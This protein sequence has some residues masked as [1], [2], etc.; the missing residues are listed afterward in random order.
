M[1]ESPDQHLI[2][3]LVRNLRGESSTNGNNGHSKHAPS[4]LSDEE[5]ISLCRKAKN[6]PKFASL[7]DDGGGQTRP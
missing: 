2:D 4:V 5:V 7:Y 6:A 3:E 1:S